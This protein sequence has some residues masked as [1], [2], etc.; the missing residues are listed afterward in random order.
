M[1]PLARDMRIGSSAGDRFAAPKTSL[2]ARLYFFKF[3]DKI[4]FMIASLPSWQAVS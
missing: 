3:P 2:R 1:G 4:V